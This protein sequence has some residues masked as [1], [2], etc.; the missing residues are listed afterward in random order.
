[1]GVCGSEQALYS[2]LKGL[3]RDR[4]EPIVA[5]PSQGPLRQRLSEIG[6][7]TFIS[8]VMIWMP[9]K[10]MPFFLFILKYYILLPWRIIK[11]AYLMRREEI[12]LVFSNELL[13]LEGGIASRLMRL[14]HI[15][16]VHNAFF[17]T[18]F[19]TY[20]P[21]GFIKWL[22]LKLA[23]RMIF[24]SQRQMQE[25]FDNTGQENKFKVATQGFDTQ[26]FAPDLERDITWRR[27]TGISENSPLVV[28]IAA[29]AKN[30]GQEDFLRA[31][32]IVRES[33][34]DTQFAIIG[35]GDKRYL[36]ELNDLALRLGLEDDVFFVDFMED[37]APVYG[38]LDVLVCASLKETF[39]RTIVEA[40]LAGKPVV[41]TKC[42]G[43]E[44][45][46]IDGVTGFLVSPKAPQE[47]A[48]AI[49]TIL[50]DGDLAQKMGRSGREK[51]ERCYSM[52]SYARNIQDI[53][54]ECIFEHRTKR[55]KNRSAGMDGEKKLERK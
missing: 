3:D 11:I 53:I 13:L 18:Y 36:K 26:Y 42:G 43:P 54:D 7:K 14:P 4:F 40:M 38:S 10:Q 52:Q 12:D 50:R 29:S 37:I 33:L 9:L 49:L 27:K 1:M 17:S 22:T 41:S 31:A 8:P 25:L 2:L 44:E 20:L 51:A 19:R 46:V 16:H 47:L 34:P 35:G 23:D 32:S 15:Y 28:L 45:I 30:K 6:V 55:H 48:G 5:V 24:V 21:V 39:G